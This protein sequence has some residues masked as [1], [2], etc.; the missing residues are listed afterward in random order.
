V[1]LGSAL[2]GLAG[3]LRHHLQPEKRLHWHIGYL[4]AEARVT[5]VWFALGGDRLECT[6]S[7]VLGGMPG[8]SSPVPGFGASD[9]RCRSH[10]TRFPKMPPLA[11]FAERLGEMGLPRPKARRAGGTGLRWYS[12]S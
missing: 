7:E 10:L 6:W 3:R 9:C 11:L 2:G 8:A 1:Y 4:L 5:R 12:P